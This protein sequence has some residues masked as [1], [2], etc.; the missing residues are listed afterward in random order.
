MSER[1][2]RQ[3]MN[4]SRR[5]D[6]RNVANL[7]VPKEDQLCNQTRLP[8][9][10]D[11]SSEPYSKLY[12]G[13]IHK[14][15]FSSSFNVVDTVRYGEQRLSFAIVHDILTAFISTL[16]PSQKTFRTKRILAKAARQNR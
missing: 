16:Q 11:L 3:Q 15:Y 7:K 14:P 13:H 1:E 9:I 5:V 4:H 10:A 8:R 12:C 6:P 2:R